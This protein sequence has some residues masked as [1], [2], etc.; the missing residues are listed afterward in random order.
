MSFFSKKDW[1]RSA[2]QASDGQGSLLW[3]LVGLLLFLV[4]LFSCLPNG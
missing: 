2:N 3:T 4:L 1:L